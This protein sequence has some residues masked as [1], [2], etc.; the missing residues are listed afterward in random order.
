M[1]LFN[2]F[3]YGASAA[4]LLALA[5]AAVYAQQTDATVRGSVVD[6]N[7]APVAGA[8]IVF[9]DTRTNAVAT[10][11]TTASGNFARTNLRV[12]GPYTVTVSAPGF[13]PQQVT[14]NSLNIGSNPSL[15]LTLDPAATDVIIVQGARI[16]GA[17]EIQNGVGTTFTSE[18]LR[19]TPLLDRDLTNVIDLDPLVSVTGDEGESGVV[20]FAGIEPRLNGF[21]VDGAVI[22]DRF[23]LEE[24]FY[25]TLRQP[26]SFDVIEAV[27]ATY[28]E[29]SVLTTGAQGGLVNTV[30]RSGGNEIDGAL[31]Y[32][33]GDDSMQ[34]DDT[35]FGPLPGDAN[36][37]ETE[38]GVT[39]SGPIIQDRLFFLVN[40]E[41]FEETNPD[42]YNLSQAELDVFD[43]IRNIF[44][45]ATD[46]NG[47]LRYDGFDPGEKSNIVDDTRT[48][49]RFFGKLDWQINDNHRASIWYTNIQE[50]R[51]QNRG[52][53]EFAFPTNAYDKTT[54]ID[55]Y[56]GQLTS[57]WTDALSTTLRVVYKEQAT[58]QTARTSVD[59]GI[60][61][62]GTFVI[63]AG[64]NDEIVAGPDQFRHANAFN[65]ESL[66]IFGAAD[67][68]WNNH[69][70]TFGGEYTDYELDN[71]FGQ[72]C[73]GV[74][75][76]ESIDALRNGN[77]TLE[78]W[79]V[80]GNECGDR[81]AVWGYNRLDLFA[82]DEW[83]ITPTF[84]IN[85]GL[86]YER[87]GSDDD[88]TP[89]GNFAAEYG[90]DTAGDLDGLDIIQPRFGFN[91]AAP[92]DIAIQGGV[93]LFSG[94]DPV[95]WFSNAYS[96]LATIFND[97]SSPDAEVTDF[98]SFGS[99]PQAALDFINT[100]VGPFNYDHIDPDFNIPSLWKAS[101]RA[102]RFFDFGPL[103]DDWLIGVQLAYTKVN[104]SAVFIN[105]AQLAGE[106]Q[107]PALAA[108]V[109]ANTGV[110][111]DGRPIYSDASST[112]DA[113]MLT[114][115][116]EGESLAATI[117]VEKE[118]DFG[119]T[120]YGSY[121]YT[122][123][124][125]VIPGS[126]SR[127][128]SN[129]RSLV[130]TDRNSAGPAG[131]S[132]FE[133]ED[134]FVFTLKYEREFFAD[135]ESQVVLKGV[136]E[137]GPVSNVGYVHFSSGGS[138]RDFPGGTSRI[139]GRA[140]GGSPFSGVD[141]LYVPTPDD[142]R[143]IFPNAELEEA[144]FAAAEEL[145]ILGNAGGF[146]DKNGIRGP[147]NQRFDLSF[148]QDLPGIPGAERFVGENRLQF[149]LDI[150]NV[151][152]LLNSDWGGQIDDP[153]FDTISLV[154]PALV[155]ATV[156]D[157]FRN[158]AITESE[159][160]ANRIGAREAGATCQAASDCVYVYDGIFGGD[161]FDEDLNDSIWQIRIG[162]RYEF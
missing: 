124:E 117:S 54:D 22:A 136:I 17:L 161:T 15:N 80:P 119:L 19:D 121:A 11:T 94:G 126:S 53:Y 154:R 18:D 100:D 90:A 134:R 118:F 16:G 50:Q 152:N 68:V 42:L 131:T 63:D 73:L 46:A 93:G 97:S 150:F 148:T 2:K 48:S 57:D 162:L 8:S 109:A 86:R 104:D 77:A 133:V 4:A 65:D 36:F 28:A 9:L 116:D 132:V 61:D 72:Y 41:E 98:A 146:V 123:S 47:D 135:L 62:F 138:F 143:V 37:D 7:G 95:V 102:E 52:D 5:P 155:T 38:W 51:L 105:R 75:E 24:A 27:A 60:A 82:Q 76:F 99:I 30:T 34:G 43:E 25:P 157:D 147:W 3:A 79:N 40:Y 153:R 69:V 159:L 85:Y 10:A 13:E 127:H 92:Y 12:G 20:S 114:N 1:A 89:G 91:W 6:A 144:F 64:L 130:T 23:K 129:Y 44:L 142:P 71:L 141:L 115:T 78:Y 32:R 45:T 112:G 149:E 74:W 139:F 56:L 108:Q 122:D 128:I 26:I 151:A 81:R 83:Q 70:F 113:I 120:I 31:F 145:G 107:D 66:Q 140:A 59:G 21:T 160:L 110:A 67:Y 88:P 29:Y 101:I 111:P 35:E 103:G 55:M 14:L 158:G 58:G 33:Y 39:V 87:Y 96:P 84:S 156:A 49:E 106:I 137:S 125:R